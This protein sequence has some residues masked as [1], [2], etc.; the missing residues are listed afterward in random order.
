MNNSNVSENQKIG[1][2]DKLYGNLK[3]SWLSVILFA[4]AA[5]VYTGIVMMI[6]PLKSDGEI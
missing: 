6:S 1:F 5:G 4:L 2:F 3:M